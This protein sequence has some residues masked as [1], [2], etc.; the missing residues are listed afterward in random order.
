[1][2]ARVQC[3]LHVHAFQRYFTYVTDA[4]G[5]L[6]ASMD[7]ARCSAYTDIHLRFVYEPRES[8][9]YATTNVL[10]NLQGLTTRASDLFAE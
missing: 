3:G 1:M 10:Y 5:L 7:I 6:H 4:C 8:I 2:V 9:P